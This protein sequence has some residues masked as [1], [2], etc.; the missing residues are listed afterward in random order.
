MSRGRMTIIGYDGAGEP[1]TRRKRARRDPEREVRD[2]G[3][4]IRSALRRGLGR[5]DI[6]TENLTIERALGVRVR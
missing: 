4:G 2:T 5:A 3:R 1:I 6:D